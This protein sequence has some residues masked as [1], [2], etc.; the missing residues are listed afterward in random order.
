MMSPFKKIRVQDWTSWFITVVWIFFVDVNHFLWLTLLNKYFKRSKCLTMHVGTRSRSKYI[1]AHM[2][3]SIHPT[4]SKISRMFPFPVSV[5]LS[6]WSPLMLNIYHS[7]LN[8][9]IFLTIVSTTELPTRE[10]QAITTRTADETWSKQN[11]TNV[12]V[13]KNQQNLTLEIYY[14]VTHAQNRLITR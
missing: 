3:R 13:L 14:F 10:V 7:T 8:N 1:S 12:I 9:N 11:R 4:K 6:N 2:S 5:R